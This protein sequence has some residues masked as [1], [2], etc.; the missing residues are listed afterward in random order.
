MKEIPRGVT[1]ASKPHSSQIRI[2]GRVHP[3]GKKTNEGDFAVNSQTAIK[4]FK[5]LA[6]SKA[7]FITIIVVPRPN[8][9]PRLTMCCKPD[10]RLP[11][12]AHHNSPE[13]FCFGEQRP[14]K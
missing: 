1:S 7:K 8:K 13:L 12:L 10:S 6:H 9:T 11:I 5:I 14:G 3:T 4:F 2:L